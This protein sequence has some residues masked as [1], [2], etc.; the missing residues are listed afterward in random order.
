M[1]DHLDMRLLQRKPADSIPDAARIRAPSVRR[2]VVTCFACRRARPP[3]VYLENGHDYCVP[4]ATESYALIG[5][6]PGGRRPEDITLDELLRMS[7]RG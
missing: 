4:C 5:L 2:P 1:V 3:Y 7:K 6:R